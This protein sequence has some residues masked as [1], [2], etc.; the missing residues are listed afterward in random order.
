M[1]EYNYE[2]DQDSRFV[3]FDFQV[4]DPRYIDAQDAATFHRGRPVGRE[5]HTSVVLVNNPGSF[6]EG[7]MLVFGGHAG[8]NETVKDGGAGGQEVRVLL[9][10]LV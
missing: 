3:R 7:R 1:F 6:Y 8:G 9:V 10:L 4:P 5:R 2:Y